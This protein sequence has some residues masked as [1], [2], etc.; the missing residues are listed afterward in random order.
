M[1][2]SVSKVGIFA[3][4]LYESGVSRAVEAPGNSPNDRSPSQYEASNDS[5][6]QGSFLSWYRLKQSAGPRC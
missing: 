2:G 6:I 4:N 3:V 5:F 1:H